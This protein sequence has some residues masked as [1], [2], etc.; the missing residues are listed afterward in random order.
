MGTPAVYPG[1]EFRK[2]SSFSTEGRGYNKVIRS[3]RRNEA[4]EGRMAMSRTPFRSGAGAVAVLL[5]CLGALAGCGDSNAGKAESVDTLAGAPGGAGF[6]DGTGLLVRFSSPAGV[7]AVGADLFVADTA[8][9]VIRRIDTATG[10]VT[11]LAGKFGV[12]GSADDPEG[13]GSLARFRSPAG[14]V[15]V[16]ATLF[17]S[18]TGNHTIRRIVSTS[19]AVTTLAGD[20]GSAGAV[21]NAAGPGGVRFSSP[22]GIASDL[23]GA[24]LFVADTGSNKIRRVTLAGAATTYAGSGSPGAVDNVGS[25]ASFS[26]PEGVAVVGSDVYVADTGNHTIRKIVP[27]G[28]VGD[29]TTFAGAA[30]IPGFADN[31]S[32]PLARFFSPASLAAIGTDL[33]VADTG[34]H[35]IR[36]ID[37]AAF[38]TAFAGAAGT[39]GSADGSFA[40]ARF[41]GPKGIGADGASLFVAD[42]ENHA[43]R[44][45]TAGG[46]VTTVAGNPPQAGTTDGTGAAARFLSPAGVAVIG[47]NVFVA[48][49]G[50]GTI[51]KIASGGGVTTLGGTAGTISSPAGIAAIGTTLYVC[52][53]VNH[54]IVRIDAGGAVTVL[55]GSQGIPGSADGSGAAALF[56]APRG[57]ASDGANLYVADTGNHAIRQV[58]PA[59]TVTTVAGLAGNSG[60]ADG[61]GSTARFLL[62]QGIAAVVAPL[63]TTLYVADTGNHTVRR[64]GVS[65]GSG[66]G[67]VSTF[68]GTS[69]TAGFADGSGGG[70]RFSSPAGIAAVGSVLYVA[71]TG[72]HSI[73][74]ITGAGTVTTFVGDPE[75][76]TTRDG[77]A[78]QALLNAPAGIA[79]I[80]GTIFFT[81]GNENVVRKVLF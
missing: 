35:V 1:A 69:G 27:A 67:S 37:A 38:V 13:N 32:G 2:S 26:S 55:A 51:R 81:D 77:D 24:A 53:N 3:D 49:T 73:R 29:V 54:T 22:R 34:N 42:T 44:R 12:P 60:S 70:A 5:L 33:Y 59:G 57:I 9:H 41:H 47:D 79:G 25:S 50:N 63:A 20:P 45:I 62:P 17:V 11:T 15:A 36:K 18:D 40:A 19:G 31:V 65:G 56:N 80:E 72:H 43:V 7:A 66:S 64:I 78:P 61:S 76:A 21:D 58:T 74:K 16:G 48:D 46:S 52:D 14:I 6:F 30:G 75:A 10:A 8:N 28:A 23:G 68:A 71:D 39:A 4:P